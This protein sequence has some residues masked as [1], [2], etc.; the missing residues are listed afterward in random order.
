MIEGIR[1]AAPADFDRIEALL[2]DAH[3]PV[4]GAREAFEVGFVAEN[5]DAIVGAVALE[6]HP[7]TALLRSLVV[8]RTMQG[9]GVGQRLTSA[10]IEEAQRRG[11]ASIY[12]L[13]TTAEAFF[14]R[15]GFVVVDRQSVPASI[16]HSVEF[17]SACPASAVA[18]GLIDTRASLAQP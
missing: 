5:R 1:R 9:K 15:F 3:L 7:D 14:P 4:D 18:M 11:L 2:R 17:H 16:Q 13:T 8:D 12:L 10:A 6:V